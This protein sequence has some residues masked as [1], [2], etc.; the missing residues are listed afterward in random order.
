M[1][2]LSTDTISFPSA[3]ATLQATFPSSTFGCGY[4]QQGRLGTHGDG[5]VGLGLGALSLI[6]QLGP[7]INHKFSYCLTPLSSNVA[8]KLQF[9]LDMTQPKV[10]S[11][12]LTTQDPP[13]FYYLTLN[14]ISIGNSSIAAGQDMIVDSGTTLT[15]LPTNIYDGVRTAMKGAIRLSPIPDPNKAFDPC[16][17]VQPEGFNP[18]DVVLHFKGAD[19]V[20]KGVNT[21]WKLDNLACLAIVPSEGTLLLGNIAQVNFEVGYDLNAKQISFAPADC[22]KY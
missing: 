10:V 2:I 12:P 3:D 7:N 4:D 20:L 8:G 16:Y 19:V 11:S 22:T 9:G 1:G 6:S 13:T 14:S 5:I 18:P 21:F 17:E 15:F